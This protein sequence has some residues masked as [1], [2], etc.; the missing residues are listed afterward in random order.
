[1]EPGLKKIYTDN[2]I[3]LFEKS[4]DLVDSTDEYRTII[5][6][7]GEM[8]FGF[9]FAFNKLIHTWQKKEEQ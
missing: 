1:M 6:K 4:V 9:E 5:L 7:I 2:D 8:L 3:K